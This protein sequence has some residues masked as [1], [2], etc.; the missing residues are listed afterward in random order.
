MGQTDLAL[1]SRNKS[2]FAREILGRSQAK[3]VVECLIW[4]CFTNRSD[5]NSIVAEDPFL[6]EMMFSLLRSEI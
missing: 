3:T 6:G 5:L 4:K 1:G 2:P